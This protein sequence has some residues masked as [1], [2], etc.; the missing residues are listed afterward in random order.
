MRKLWIALVFVSGCTASEDSTQVLEHIRQNVA[1]KLSK[2]VNYTCTE[3]LNRTYYRNNGFAMEMYGPEAVTTPKN[4]LLHDRLRLDVAVSEGKEIYAWHGAGRFSASEVTDFVRNGPISS[5]QFVGYLRNVFLTPGVKFEYRGKGTENG[6]GVYRFNFVVPLQRSGNRVH[7]PRGYVNVP[8]HGWLTARASDLQLASLDVIDDQIPPDSNLE[9]VH[10]DLKYQVARISQR[11]ALLPSLFI[12]QIQDTGHVFSVSRG[13]Y[14]DCREFGSE[15][16][17]RFTGTDE[18]AQSEAVSLSP[19]PSLP[20]GLSLRVALKTE[21]NDETA[22]AGDSVEGVLVRGV[23]IP[24]SAGIIPKNAILHGII[25]RFETYFRPETQYDLR[26]EFNR[27]TF[28]K[29]TYRLKAV[30]EPNAHEFYPVY[31]SI[32]PENVVKELRAGSMLIESKHVRLRKNFTANWRTVGLE[33]AAARL[34]N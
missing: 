12:L 10:T 23:K 16:T 28:G 30:H 2:S 31:G 8:Y 22:Y 20:A 15:S 17:V 13:D 27:L 32:V 3:T 18:P 4:A 25:T 14:S 11:E 1:G 7:T 26:I 21:I 24:D 19:L 6:T 9:S 33:N 34:G 29:Q 5:G